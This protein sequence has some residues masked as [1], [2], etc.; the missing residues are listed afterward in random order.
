MQQYRPWE[1]WME[2]YLAVKNLGVLDN[3]KLNISQQCTLVNKK[4]KVSWPAS[5]IM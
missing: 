5:E 1:E 2:G 4:I 3:S